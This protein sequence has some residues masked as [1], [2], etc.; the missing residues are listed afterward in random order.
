MSTSISQKMGREPAHPPDPFAITPR[1]DPPAC[2]ASLALVDYS[3]A[4][5]HLSRSALGTFPTWTTSKLFSGE[6]LPALF[7]PMRHVGSG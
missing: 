7:D 4:T 5:G 1:V 3:P 2:H 6:R